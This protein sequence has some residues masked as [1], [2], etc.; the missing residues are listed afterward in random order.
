M[1]KHHYHQC[2]QQFHCLIQD[3]KA[4]AVALVEA[5][6]EDVT[7][8]YVMSQLKRTRDGALVSWNLQGLGLRHLPSEWNLTFSGFLDLSDNQLTTIPSGFASVIVHGDLNLS[9]NK[10]TT[11]PEEP[12]TAQFAQ[13][14][15][16]VVP[17]LPCPCRTSHPSLWVVRST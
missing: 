10:L 13:I 12:E 4:I 6:N 5:A 7:L 1:G 16:H 2:S 17:I 3:P 11:L 15:N 14:P 9:Q 8:A